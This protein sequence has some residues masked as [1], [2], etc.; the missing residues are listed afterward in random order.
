V[1]AVVPGRRLTFSEREEIAWR[2]DRKQRVR[3]IARLRREF[4]HRPEMHVSHETIYQALCVQGKGGLRAEVG[5]ALRCGRARR[6]PRSGDTDLRGKV[7]GMINISER[8]AEA[9]GR[10]VPGRCPGTGKAT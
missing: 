7:P 10:A 8:P 4:P 2:R 6:R 3:Q 5:A 1:E 9:A